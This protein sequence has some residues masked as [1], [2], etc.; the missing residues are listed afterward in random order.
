MDQRE[1]ILQFGTGNFLRA[2]VDLFV[3]EANA[4]GQDAGSV[5]VVQSMG[6]T[7][8]DA[9]ERQ[10][11]RYHVIVRGLVDGKAA[12]SIKTVASVSRALAA[13]DAWNE[14]LRV[15][16][17]PELA[18]IV[19]N[20]TEKGYDLDPRDAP[21]DLPPRSFPAKLLACLAHRARSGSPPLTVLPC[22]L[23]EN[24]AD[25]LRSVVLELATRWGVDNGTRRWISS[26]CTWPNTLVDRIVPGPPDEHP[27]LATDALVTCAEPYALWVIEDLPRAR[28]LFDHP[29]IIRTTDVAPYHLRKVRVLNG[30]HSAL[31]TKAMPLGF[32]T[33]REAV[34]DPAI[35]EWLRELLFDE[36]VATLDGRVAG[37][38]EYAEETLTRFRNPYLDHRLESIALH[39]DAKV[40]VRLRPTVGEFRERF[41]RD[42]EK[43]TQ[44][45]S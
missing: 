24:N 10:R 16:A 23:F 26:E 14:I 13:A 34:E 4:S 29:A 33:V 15:A 28:A 41:G 32:D 35:G 42:P 44:I 3:E 45:L 43:L 37:V 25:R 31:V 9:L 2:F 36:I 8:A 17:S 1:T 22:E 18:W 21:D 6:T 39:H 40:E 19:S 20:T 27:L 5:V 11:G 12:E 7:R 38:R 30:A